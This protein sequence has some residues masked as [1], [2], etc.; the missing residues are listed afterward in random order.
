M[1]LALME[2]E[3]EEFQ[4]QIFL[5]ITN[6]EERLSG[7][8]MELLEKKQNLGRMCKDRR[9][10]EMEEGRE[11]SG[12]NGDVTRTAGNGSQVSDLEAKLLSADVSDRKEEKG[13]T[14]RKQNLEGRTWNRRNAKMEGGR[15][16]L[17]ARSGITRSAGGGSQ[18]PEM[19][20]GLLSA[21]ANN[22]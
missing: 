16:K 7:E 10:A 5:E 8:E 12:V 19:E 20:A 15:Q 14:E 2:R 9:Y 4:K 13:H 17:T 1:L 3:R 11:K 22:R 18:T 6:L 21:E